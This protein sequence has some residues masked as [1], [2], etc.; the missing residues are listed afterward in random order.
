MGQSDPLLDK[1]AG[2]VSFELPSFTETVPA[3]NE[4]AGCDWSDDEEG[5]YNEEDN[6]EDQNVTVDS[7]GSWGSGGGDYH[8]QGQ[9]RL[10]SDAEFFEFCGSPER[11]RWEGGVGRESAS[12][13]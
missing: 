8:A 9:G 4:I 6:G 10:V 5:D 7:D 3:R 12:L 11:A 13:F 2:R 1:N